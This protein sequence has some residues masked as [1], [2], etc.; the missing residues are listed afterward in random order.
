MFV[1]VALSGLAAIVW[2]VCE[3][4]NGGGFSLDGLKGRRSRRNVRHLRH[5]LLRSVLIYRLRYARPSL[6]P[7]VPLGSGCVGV[8][9]LPR[10]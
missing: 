9:S 2:L 5:G 10:C 4:G 8:L 3:D 6:L 7:L 1:G